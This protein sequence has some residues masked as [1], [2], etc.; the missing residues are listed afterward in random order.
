[1]DWALCVEVLPQSRCDVRFMLAVLYSEMV[2][3]MPFLIDF[4]AIVADFVAGNDI[5]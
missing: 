4:Q 3:I 2:N 1:M 5:A